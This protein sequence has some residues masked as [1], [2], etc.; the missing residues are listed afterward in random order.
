MGLWPGLVPFPRRH[1]P[2]GCA[3]RRSEVGLGP[4][5]SFRRLSA[6]SGVP[7]A[8]ACPSR[9][10]ASVGRKWQSACPGMLFCPRHAVNGRTG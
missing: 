2:W 4:R 5:T 3:D 7:E 9:H 1:R 10:A 6:G 8:P